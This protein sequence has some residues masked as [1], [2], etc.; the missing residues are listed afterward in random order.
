MAL[1][2]ELYPILKSYTNKYNTPYI[3]IK[4]FIEFLEKY[5][6]RKMEEHPEWV[7]WTVNTAGKFWAEL[8]PLAEAEKLILT[9]D[10]A[11]DRIF[12]PSYYADLIREAYQSPDEAAMDPFPSEEYLRIILPEEHVSYLNVESDLA[13]Y[14]EREGNKGEADYPLDSPQAN[15]IVKLIFPDSFGHALVLVPMIPRRI[16]EAAL[17]KV[18]YFLRKGGNKEY[19]LHK[20]SPQFQNKEKYLRD[21]LDQILIRPL[22]CITNMENFGD[23]Q[24]LFWTYFCTLAKNDIKKKNEKLGEDIAVFQAVSIIEACNVLYKARAVKEREKELA[25]KSLELH[26]GK[27]PY[28]Y[29]LDQITQFTSD[30]GVLLLSQYSEKEL[31]A[32]IKK[33]TTESQDRQLPEWLVL[34]GKKDERWFI[35][36]SRYLSLCT[37]LLIENRPKI[38]QAIAKRWTGLLRS[39]RTEP[40]M[41]KDSDFNEL[42]ESYTA[43]ISPVL[44]ALLEDQKLVWVYEEMEHEEAGASAASR[45]FSKGRL[46]PISD[47]YT[48]RRKDLITDARIMLPFWYSV[49]VFFAIAALFYRLGKGKKKRGQDSGE[50]AGDELLAETEDISGQLRNTAREIEMRLVPAGYTLES[51]LGELESRW[52]RLIGRENRQNLIED[53]R[54][55]VRDC[56]RTLFRTQKRKT[57]SPESIKKMAFALI[58]RNPTLQSIKDQDTLRIYIELYMVKLLEH[59]KR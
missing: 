35:L 21:I 5:S 36:K 31:D 26:M 18:R 43:E 4:E 54:S 20:L 50:E 33:K 13:P 6:K 34:T 29:T 47:L 14:F 52:V 12:M 24:Y 22:D 55:L 48:L 11:G 51:Y 30:K 19:T 17:L 46:L 28:Y 9:A 57:I 58:A 16:M 38:K 39:F 44:M 49:P 10:T 7:K 23:F 40:P 42:L 56:L 8:T 41:E 15:A 25:F 2:L 59:I 45:I 27:P 3:E 53:V 1:N 32:L 37:R